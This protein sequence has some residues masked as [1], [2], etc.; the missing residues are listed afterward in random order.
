MQT[1]QNLK[2]LAENRHTII[3]QHLHLNRTESDLVVLH[4]DEEKWI[5]QSILSLNWFDTFLKY[6]KRSLL[7]FW[8]QLHIWYQSFLIGFENTAFRMSL[9]AF[10]MLNVVQG[11]QENIRRVLSFPG[12][13]LLDIPTH[14]VPRYFSF[15]HGLPIWLCSANVFNFK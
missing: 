11:T 2:Y 9:K 5:S 6:I 1:F 4:V 3:Y 7:F 12:H 13:S 14:R 8:Y 10:F 15:G